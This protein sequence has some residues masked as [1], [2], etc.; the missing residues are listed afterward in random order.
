MTNH[1]QSTKSRYG[2]IEN[3]YSLYLF[4]F[5]FG[6]NNSYHCPG[7]ITNMLGNSIWILFIVTLITWERLLVIL[8]SLLDA[9]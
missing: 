5:F 2:L 8:Q 1:L 3:P 6:I 4:F 9:T 7:E